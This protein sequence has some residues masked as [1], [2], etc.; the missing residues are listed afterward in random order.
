M[1]QWIKGTRKMRSDFQQL[2]LRY[3]TNDDLNKYEK[4]DA[5]KHGD[6]SNVVINVNKNKSKFI[7]CDNLIFNSMKECENYYSLG[8]NI[9]TTWLNGKRKMPLDFQKLN[10]R[11]ATN[12]DLN[13]YPRYTLANN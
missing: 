4:Y 8:R 13:T 7:Y 2:N 3:A 10:L 6:K 1:Y 11:Y 9:I 12:E 5:N